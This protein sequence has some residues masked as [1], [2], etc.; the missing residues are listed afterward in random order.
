V[1]DLPMA[2]QPEYSL[3]WDLFDETKQRPHFSDKTVVAGHTEQKNAEI[4]DLGF[5]LCIDTVCCKY[6]WLTAIDM[7]TREIWQASR[8]GML[9]DADETS[10]RHQLKE[11][12]K[13]I[14]V[15]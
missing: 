4:L 3:R 7:S 15:A 10:H 13:P 12:L 9:R 6:G 1:A 2:E 11:L 8:W 5:A 14:A